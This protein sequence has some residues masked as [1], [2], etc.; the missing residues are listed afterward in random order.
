MGPPNLNLNFLW[1][2]LVDKIFCVIAIDLA[3]HIVSVRVVV[4]VVV[5][6]VVGGSLC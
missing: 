3:I 2:E 1:M 6:I 4:V 5:V